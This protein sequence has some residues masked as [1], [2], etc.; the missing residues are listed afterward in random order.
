M[1]FQNI[2]KRDKG[3][4]SSTFI[5]NLNATNLLFICKIE[6]PAEALHTT[7]G[8]KD[9]LLAREEW[10]TVRANIDLEHRFRAHRFKAIATGARY[11]S[12]RIV[13]MDSV[14]H[15]LSPENQQCMDRSFGRLFEPLTSRTPPVPHRNA[16]MIVHAWPMYVKISSLV[17]PDISC[18]L[19]YHP[20]DPTS[21]K[22]Q[23]FCIFIHRL[24]YHR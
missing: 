24:F 5:P 6:A 10:V 13:W 7:C 8:V 4:L 15:R 23:I 11:C 19:P 1:H 16:N 12:F 17:I 20:E 14:F 9:A 22:R 2:V 21:A 3:S 18:L